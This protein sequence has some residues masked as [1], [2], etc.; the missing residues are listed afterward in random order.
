MCEHRSP[1]LGPA[2]QPDRREF[3]RTTGR[4]T[5][6]AAGLTTG[7]A[8]V[9]APML[10]EP[11]A[12][13]R[14]VSRT[15]TGSFTGV[16]TA[17]WHYVPVR[18]PRGVREIEVSYDYEST[19]T[20]IGASANVIDI[21]LF[22]ASGHGLGNAAGF[23]GWS[24]GARR[25][26]RVSRTGATPGY[27]PGPLEPGLWHVVLGPVGIIPPGVDWTMTVTL[28]FGRPGRRFRPS[29]APRS[30]PGTGRRWY[31]GDLHLHTVH[32]DGSRTPAQMVAAAA[33]AGLDFFASTEHNT[34]SASLVWGRHAPADLLVVNG[35]EVTTRE[36]HWLALGLPAGAWVDWRYRSTDGALP[37]FLDQVRDLGGLA[38][39]A[40]PTVPIPSTGWSQGPLEQADAIE[41][42]NGPWTLDD[43]G[44]LSRWH[45]MLVAGRYVP[46]VGSSD[47]HRPDQPVGLPQTVVLAD[48]LS[49]GALVRSLKAGR[50]WLAE[51]ADVHLDFIVSG[52]S[53]EA[54]CGGRLPAGA[55][56]TV[57]ARVDVQ[58]VPGCVATL[59]GPTG[60]LASV[61]ADAEGEVALELTLPAAAARFLRVEV[62]RPGSVDQPP[63]DPTQDA[64]GSAM[65]A[66]TNPVFVDLG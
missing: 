57:R 2:E 36:G 33:A 25:S 56:D 13:G 27:L 50:A 41:V 34:S 5:A 1:A 11:A 6:V 53:G 22:D 24:G 19:P 3:L 66:L 52:P 48:T 44:T 9:A 46:V 61:P 10:F 7:L 43:E 8:T 59:V 47:S 29:P 23:R 32:S 31:R 63:T 65:V 4:A 12:A 20:P 64:V 58:G 16:D 17:D 30:V 62:R 28:H 55:G 37:R 42:W 18:V 38:I 40:H 35:E 15:Y 54:T 39:I 49:T 60:P 21:G 51:S 45:A 26:F 14:S